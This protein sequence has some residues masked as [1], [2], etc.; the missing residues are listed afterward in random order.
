MKA[1]KLFRRLLATLFAAL[2]TGGLAAP[3]HAAGATNL[4]IPLS[5]TISST[6]GPL[7]LSGFVHLV[8]PGNP[9]IPSDPAR[10]ET[11]L[12]QVRAANDTASCSAIGTQSF[13]LA[14][15]TTP[16]TGSYAFIPGNPISPIDPCR[17]LGSLSIDY[18]LTVTEGGAITAT[19]T[20][21]T[22]F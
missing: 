15:A 6:A 1:T 5:G 9:I 3:S 22:T 11:N 12:V 4:L 2:L 10:V 8:V 17:D 20:P 16:F 13:T 14:T 18:Q 7:A 19:A 21:H